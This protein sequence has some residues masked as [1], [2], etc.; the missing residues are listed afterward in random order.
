LIKANCSSLPSPWSG[1]ESGV[2]EGVFWGDGGRKILEKSIIKSDP[3]SDSCTLCT[4]VPKA[5]L[6]NIVPLFP[7]NSA[8]EKYFNG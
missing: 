5:Q 1:L 7:S 4:G 6:F 2:L 8:M 3:R